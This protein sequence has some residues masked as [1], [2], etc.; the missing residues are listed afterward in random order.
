MF[1][2]ISHL[3]SSVA[4]SYWSNFAHLFKRQSVRLSVVHFLY[5][6]KKDTVKV[7]FVYNGKLEKLVLFIV[8]R[9]FLS[10]CFVNLR[11]SG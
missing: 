10:L 9:G 2:V 8:V 11:S 1:C 7:Q 3:L 4:H 5:L 6:G